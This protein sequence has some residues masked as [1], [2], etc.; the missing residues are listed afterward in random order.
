MNSNP[1]LYFSA[2]PNKSE[3]K[4]ENRVHQSNWHS[5]LEED[6]GETLPMGSIRTKW[7][8]AHGSLQAASKIEGRHFA[9]RAHLTSGLEMLLNWLAWLQSQLS[10]LMT[11]E[12]NP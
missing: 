6:G 3:E 1:T 10:W 2:Y 7:V 11:S 12:L 5:L 4:E 8:V 9:N